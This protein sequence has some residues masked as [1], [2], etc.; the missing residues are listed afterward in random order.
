MEIRYNIVRD[1]AFAA[2]KA[3]YGPGAVQVTDGLLT[4]LTINER[5]WLSAVAVRP[6][7]L[8]T[9]TYDEAALVRAIRTYVD[10]KEVAA[11]KF[12]DLPWKEVETT[13]EYTW[14]DVPP[15]TRLHQAVTD[16]VTAIK[17]HKAARAAEREA[18]ERKA[19]LDRQTAA[20]RAKVEREAAAFADAARMRAYVLE[21]VPEYRQAAEEGRRV[22]AQAIQ[23]AWK[24]VR[25]TLE[26][27]AKTVRLEEHRVERLEAPKAFTYAMR[28]KIAAALATLTLPWTT[29]PTLD[30]WRIDT[31]PAPECESGWRAA[32]RVTVSW[33]TNQEEYMYFWADPSPVH[34]HKR[35]DY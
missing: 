28:D 30:M 7:D 29:P 26:Q 4:A 19:D 24:V 27:E 25:A 23:H 32:V 3:A 13:A 15:E 22:N 17:R 9:P 2:G 21:H 31:C 16:R 5:R 14:P 34:V 11:Q 20:E 12:V 6:V 18:A 33:L 1:V 10:A 35:A 8:D